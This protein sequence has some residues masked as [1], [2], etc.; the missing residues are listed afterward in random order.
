MKKIMRLML[1]RRMLQNVDIFIRAAEPG[2][3]L[4]GSYSFLKKVGAYRLRLLVLEGERQK[5]KGERD[6]QIFLNAALAP[7]PSP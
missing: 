4:P 3:F 2:S 1:L 5:N 7:P 6:D